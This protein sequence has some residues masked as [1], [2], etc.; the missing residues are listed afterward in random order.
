M[1]FKKICFPSAIEP[2]VPSFHTFLAINTEDV[3][4][5]VKSELSVYIEHFPP[6][7]LTYSY[8]QEI[9][10]EWLRKAKAK[11]ELINAAAPRWVM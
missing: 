6:L 8:M 9:V 1:Y 7:L 2:A 10:V 3:Y 4:V 11:Q 5:D